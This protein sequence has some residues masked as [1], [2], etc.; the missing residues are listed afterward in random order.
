MLAPG[1][2][3]VNAQNAGLRKMLPK[4]SFNPLCT[5]SDRGESWISAVRARFRYR[6]PVPAVMAMKLAH[7]QVQDKLR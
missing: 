5:L 4:C 2:V 7:G 3:P 1:R 6:R